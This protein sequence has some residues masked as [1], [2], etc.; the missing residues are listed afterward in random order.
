MDFITS[1]SNLWLQSEMAC[2]EEFWIHRELLAL[3]REYAGP[4]L[5]CDFW[6]FFL[7]SLD[8]Q[9]AVEQMI[10]D[11]GLSVQAASLLVMEQE[12]MIS[13]MLCYLC[14]ECLLLFSSDITLV[15]SMNL[16]IIPTECSCYDSLPHKIAQVLQQSHTSFQ[17]P[18]L[19][20]TLAT[21]ES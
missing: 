19:G 18:K 20:A 21:R 10:V 15:S 4:T 12:N 8:Q 9:M 6:K 17:S 13:I 5:S 1:C 14:C 7:F 11:M 16:N 3:R 2:R